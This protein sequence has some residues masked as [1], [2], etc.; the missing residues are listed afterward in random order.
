MTDHDWEHAL[1]GVHALVWEGGE[2]VGHASVIQRRL[3]YG[4]DGGACGYTGSGLPQIRVM[5]GGSQWSSLSLLPQDGLAG[6]PLAG[7]GV[8]GL[9]HPAAAACFLTPQLER[10]RDAWQAERYQRG[11]ISQRPG[12]SNNPFRPR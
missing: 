10:A 7:S 9:L 1:G 2:L 11:E 5:P 12:Y 6:L 8:S 4:N 3:L